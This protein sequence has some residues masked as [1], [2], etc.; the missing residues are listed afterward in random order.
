MFGAKCCLHS[1]AAPR[2]LKCNLK[3]NHIVVVL[4]FYGLCGSHCRAV[5]HSGSQN[6]TE[7]P[8]GAAFT[9]KTGMLRGVGASSAASADEESLDMFRFVSS[10]RGSAGRLIFVCVSIILSAVMCRMF[11]VTSDDINSFH[12]VT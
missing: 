12:F 7:R 2:S 6:S 3:N 11:L 5:D 4:L 8:S 10:S 1:P 9:T